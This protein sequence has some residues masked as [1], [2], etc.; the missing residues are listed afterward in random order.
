[1]TF[2]ERLRSEIEY[3]GI[4]QKELA[5]RAGIKKRA[6]DMY[7]GLQESMPPADVAVRLAQELGISVEYLVTGKEPD[8]SSSMPADERTLLEIFKKLDSRDRSVVMK[9]AQFLSGGKEQEI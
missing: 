6:F 5:E 1:M 9:L 8:E 3:A 4:S 2:T 7:V